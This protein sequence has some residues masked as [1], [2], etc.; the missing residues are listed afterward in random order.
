MTQF[1]RKIKA[2]NKPTITAT[3]I[4]AL[5]R[6]VGGD[7]AVKCTHMIIFQFTQKIEK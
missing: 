4:A 1:E 7:S 2:T 5:L 6:D 3:S